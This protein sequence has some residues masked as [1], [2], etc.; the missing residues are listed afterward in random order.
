MVA[1]DLFVT[2]ANEIALLE[3]RPD[4]ELRVVDELGS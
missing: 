1:P 3:V 4:G 2:G